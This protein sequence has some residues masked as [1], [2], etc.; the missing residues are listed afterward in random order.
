MAYQRTNPALPHAP[1]DASAN[2]EL[3]LAL[4]REVARQD[5]THLRSEPESPDRSEDASPP[6]PEGSSEVVSSANVLI[7]RVAA[8]SLEQV[9]NV[10]SDLQDLRA[11]LHSE[12][13]RVQ[14]E[15]SSYL[16]L[17]QTAIGSTKVIAESIPRLKSLAGGSGR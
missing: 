16:K 14:Q 17:S 11:F 2:P 4:M 5:D 10:I 1:E 3:R 13:E 7:Q 8:L 12:G 6:E 9:E 15:I